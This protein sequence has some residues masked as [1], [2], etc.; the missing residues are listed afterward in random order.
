MR[1]KFDCGANFCSL[2]GIGS[3]P[4]TR[5]VREL[6]PKQVS[7]QLNRYFLKLNKYR[8]V[9]SSVTI[10]LVISRIAPPPRGITNLVTEV[11]VTNLY[12]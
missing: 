8:F 12:L 10:K 5:A 9:A 2:Y 1:S 7:G 4:R 3:W 11:D 6:E